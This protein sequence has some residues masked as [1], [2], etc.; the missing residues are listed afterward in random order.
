MREQ[1]KRRERERVNNLGGKAVNDER[2][3]EQE[4]LE[5][6]HVISSLTRSKREWKVL[7]RKCG[8]VAACNKKTRR[9]EKRKHPTQPM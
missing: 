3:R 8:R 7:V 9:Q 5:K 6:M 2:V 1:K 4:K